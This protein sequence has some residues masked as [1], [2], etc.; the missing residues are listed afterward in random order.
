MKFKQT[1]KFR[2][3]VKGVSVYV[4]AKQIRWGFGDQISTNAAVYAAFTSLQDMKAVDNAT[5]GLCARY[6]EVDVQ[7]D[8]L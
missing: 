4:T 7:I 8:T 6:G 5:V 2:V 3:I 1:Q